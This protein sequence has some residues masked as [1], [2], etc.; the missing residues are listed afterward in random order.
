M[1]TPDKNSNDAKEYALGVVKAWDEASW[2]FQDKCKRANEDT[3]I[4]N[5]FDVDESWNWKL[6]VWDETKID[7]AKETIDWVW[8]K[9]EIYTNVFNALF[10]DDDTLTLDDNIAYNTAVDLW[11]RMLHDLIAMNLDDFRNWEMW[12]SITNIID[13]T[14]L[15]WPRAKLFADT[16]GQ[17][18]YNVILEL[19][20]LITAGETAVLWQSPNLAAIDNIRKKWNEEVENILNIGAKN[21]IENMPLEWRKYAEH[22]R[23]YISKLI[24]EAH[25]KEDTRVDIVL[26]WISFNIGG[27]WLWVGNNDNQK[28]NTPSEWNKIYAIF[29]KPTKDWIIWPRSNWITLIRKTMQRLAGDGWE[30]LSFEDFMNIVWEDKIKLLSDEL[31][32]ECSWLKMWD[33]A[34]GKTTV[35][36]P[37]VAR[38]LMWWLEEGNDFAFTSQIHVT[39]N[40]ARKIKEWINKNENSNLWVKLDLSNVKIP[41]IIEILQAIWEIEDKDAIWSW[42]MWVPYALAMKTKI[43]TDLYRPFTTNEDYLISIAEEEWYEI[44]EIWEIT[45]WKDKSIAT[46]VWIW[47]ST[48]EL[49]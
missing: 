31:I 2:N 46:W 24:M 38:K 23:S 28:L 13:I 11:E 41:Q 26:K 21:E 32:T 36:N 45:D 34:T 10:N 4:R 43:D 39:W 18:M 12:V 17:A 33:I 48:I 37:F 44:K 29:E 22:I 27:T 1:N 8:T 49:F 14:H 16:L 25:E 5:L 47:K 3:G 6:I 35:F 30:M 9:V 40:P 15:K 20:I 42:N 7:Y 19:D